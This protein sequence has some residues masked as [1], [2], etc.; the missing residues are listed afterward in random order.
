MIEQRARAV[1][2]TYARWR[3]TILALALAVVALPVGR[4]VGQGRLPELPS[5]APVIETVGPA[6]VNISVSG[7]REQ[8]IDPF[9]RQFFPNGGGRQ[10]FRSAGSGVIVDAA[11]GYI[12]TNHHVVEDADEITVTLS[13]DR[14]FDAEVVG[15]DPGSD[16]AVLHVEAE[17]LAEMTLGDSDRV[18]VGDYVLAIGNPFGLD[19]TVTSGI[20]SGL[21]RRGINPEGYEDFIQTDA[22][23]NPGNSG[24]ALVNL[25]GELIG[26]NSAILSGSGG[27]IGIGF[28]IPVNMARSIMDQI[29]DYGSVR[30]GLLG[31]NIAQ[32]TPEIAE[33]Y[34]LDG[35]SGALVTAVST[36]SAAER[37]GLQ[38]NDVIVSVNGQSITDPLALRNAIGL[39][40]PG[41]RV[42]VA[43]IRDGERRTVNAV[44]GELDAPALAADNLGE[45]DPR[46]DG[47]ELATNSE[48]RP[49]YNG[50]PGVL[51]AAVEAGS[52]AAQRGLETGDV[53][54]HV[55]R[56]RVR[57]LDEAREIIESARSVVLQ[58]SRDNRSFL[59]LMQ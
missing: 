9:F 30:R 7:S 40:R 52:P 47:A 39:L 49:D 23:I 56:Q 32:L 12:L 22:S 41:D 10:Q 42:E 8:Q 13:D 4:S 1:T 19:H 46:F 37:A 45:T 27:N 11:R 17:D 53:I 28:A 15:S 33:D 20:V 58:V 3:W 55:N 31:V 25:N 38:I 6:V 36:G 57:T 29:V 51:V 35:T 5:L 43:F 59:V 16:I 18:R 48:Q 44:L 54:T 26:V 24:G 50:V 21:G 34:E 14:S 2:P